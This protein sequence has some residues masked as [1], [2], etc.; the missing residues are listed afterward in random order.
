MIEKNLSANC[1]LQ[2]ADF[3]WTDAICV[4][5]SI[6]LHVDGWVHKVDILPV[7]LF[8]KQFNGFT[9]SLKMNDLPFPEETDNIIDVRIVAKA[10]DIVVSDTGFLF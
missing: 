7:Q 10:Q 9:K 8:A 1:G 5:V 3:L 6:K 4:R 2:F